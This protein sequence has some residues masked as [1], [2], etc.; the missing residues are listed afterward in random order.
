MAYFLDP[1]LAALA[2][3]RKPA[4]QARIVPNKF[5]KPCDGCGAYVQ[6]REGRLEKVGGAWKVYHLS[7]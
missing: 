5:P 3:G 6:A 4:H 2:E 1:E 7:C